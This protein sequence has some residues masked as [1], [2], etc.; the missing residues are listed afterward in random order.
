MP[1]TESQKIE[2][3]KLNDD[4]LDAHEIADKLGVSFWAVADVKAHIAK[5]KN[6]A[7][8]EDAEVPDD[9]IEQKFGL[10]S[11]MQKALR[12][13][14]GQLEAGLEIIDGGKEKKVASGFID[15]G[16]RLP[17]LD[18]WRGISIL[19]VIA[20]HMLPLAPKWFG[21]NG[22]SGALGMCLFFTLSGFLITRTL[23]HDPSVRNFA[24]RR[25]CRI[26]P[27]AWLFSLIALPIARAASAD[28]PATLLFYANLPPFW[29]TPLTAHLWSLCVEMQFYL[30][31][32]TLFAL[33]GRRGL[34]LL[35]VACLAVTTARVVEGAEISI[36]TGFRV[37]EI[38][39]GACLA[40]AYENILLGGALRKVLSRAN[41]LVLLVLLLIACHPR[42]GAMNYLRPYLAAALVGTTIY[43]AETLLAQRLQHRI[44]TYFGEISYAL[45]VLHPLTYHGWLGSG[46]LL[47][48][49][50]KRPLAFALSIG[51]AHL[52]TR[53]YESRWIA[54]GKRHTVRARPPGAVPDTA[55]TRSVI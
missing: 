47:A 19:A 7:S 46:A 9:A 42:G 22:T 25:V 10:E 8:A 33:M 53:Y 32:G 26:V 20:A 39:S 36:T 4:G 16:A 24:I 34:M 44:L 18:G 1:L 48:K 45:Y 40:L 49:Y 38:L 52:S 12:K 54:W 23:I 3:K 2:V 50:S 28:Y 13:N 17:M 31:I 37:D 51:G 14:I 5:F 11:D 41:S 30:L 29:L 6:Q 21:L 27:L 15:I 43:Q 35:P 55:R